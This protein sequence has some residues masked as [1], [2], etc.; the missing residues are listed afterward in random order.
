[1]KGFIKT[2]QFINYMLNY[3][4]YTVIDQ[5]NEFTWHTI[6]QIRNNCAIISRELISKLPLPI[7]SCEAKILEATKLKM[8]TKYKQL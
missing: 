5:K 3:L 2:S 8:I 4:T 1:M 6:L 7:L